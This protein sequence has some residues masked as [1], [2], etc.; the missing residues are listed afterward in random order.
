MKP[1]QLVILGLIISSP[2][3]AFAQTNTGITVSTSYKNYSLGETIVIS[4]KVMSLDEGIPIIMQ[5]WSGGTMVNLAQFYPDSKSNY[6]YNILAEKPNFNLGTYVVKVSYGEGKNAETTFSIKDSESFDGHSS[7]NSTIIITMNEEI[8]YLNKPNNIIRANVDFL[9]YSPSDGKYFM[10]I[11][12]LPKGNVL[13]DSEIFPKPSGNDLWSVQ[14]A[15][16]ILESNIKKGQDILVGEFEIQIRSEN[17]PEIGIARF[18][19][20]ENESKNPPVPSPDQETLDKISGSSIP[21]WVRNTAEWWAEGSIAD[22]E[23][24]SGIQYLIQ[25]EIISIPK[26]QH[27]SGNSQEIPS[28]IKNNAEWW[29]KGLISD[30]DFLKGIQ[31]LV[32]KGIILVQ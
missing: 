2:L 9:N 32:E 30:D 22:S 8:F 20:F 15:Y 21:D 10:K 26:T 4:G 31:Y 23:F 17:N 12:Y 7:N 25:E 1:Y 27:T 5:I 24:V 13:K 11:T 16:P 28:W 29:S 6:S 18:K 19:I 3:G 14:I